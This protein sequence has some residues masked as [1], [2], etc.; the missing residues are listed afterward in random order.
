MKCLSLMQP[1]ATLIVIGAKRYET[2]KWHT[3]LLGPLAI[4]AG[5]HFSDKARALCVQEPFRSFLARA[6]YRQSADLPRGAVLGTVELVKCLPV[7]TVL[8][9]LQD[10]PE[11]LAFGDHRKARWAWQLARPLPLREPY[12]CR[13]RL[14]LF[15]VHF[16]QELF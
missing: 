3:D 5:R 14:G 11:E 16:Q 1:F 12:R 4:H 9:L 2:R 15:D 13:G 7:P 10:R 6:G 8:S